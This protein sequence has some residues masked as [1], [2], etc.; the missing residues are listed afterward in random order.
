MAAVY[1]KSKLHND[2]NER[3]ERRCPPCGDCAALFPVLRRPKSCSSFFFT[4]I[5]VASSAPVNNHDDGISSCFLQ[6]GAT[7]VYCCPVYISS[8]SSCVCSRMQQPF[9]RQT[10]RVRNI[11]K[12]CC[13]CGTVYI[14]LKY[15]E[16]NPSSDIVVH[17]RHLV[18]THQIRLNRF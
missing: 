2:C 9:F 5:T 7:R 17:Q 3:R 6:L 10:A 16:D 15:K 12:K 13:I 4:Y 14:L 1:D 11:S 8:R 18:H